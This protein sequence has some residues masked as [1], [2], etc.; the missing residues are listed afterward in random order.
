[1]SHFKFSIDSS[2][3]QLSSIDIDTSVDLSRAKKDHWK[4][5]SWSFPVSKFLSNCFCWNANS[6]N[7]FVFS[8]HSLLV[9]AVKH[10][11]INSMLNDFHWLA[12]KY[13]PQKLVFI[14]FVKDF[15]YNE[16][17]HYKCSSISDC[18][19]PVNWKYCEDYLVW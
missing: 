14:I 5:F 8:R 3:K 15:C 17:V 1:M 6:L 7:E 2:N 11:L 10:D 18:C 9:V 4:W 16:K 13:T 12:N 19:F